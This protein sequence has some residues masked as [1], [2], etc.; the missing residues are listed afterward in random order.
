MGG[1]TIWDEVAKQIVQAIGVEAA[2][3]LLYAFIA[4]AAYPQLI[5]LVRQVSSGGKPSEEL[6]EKFRELAKNTKTPERYG[7]K[8]LEKEL[9]NV[10]K[11]AVDDVEND[12]SVKFRVEMLKERIKT[13]EETKSELL[14]EFYKTVDDEKRKK[15]EENLRKIDKRIKE[16]Y[17]RLYIIMTVLKG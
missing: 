17:E 5:Q 15:I 4:S 10:L 6:V 14:A 1:G 12:E 11:Q 7:R 9:A 13:L 3:G 16:E 2:K 8:E